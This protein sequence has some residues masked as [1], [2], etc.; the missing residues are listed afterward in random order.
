M[1]CGPVSI[2]TATSYV[3]LLGDGMTYGLTWR[4]ELG[5]LIYSTHSYQSQIA[6]YLRGVD[7]EYQMIEALLLPYLLC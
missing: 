2:S 7:F 1:H 4:R 3:R 5:V 6:E